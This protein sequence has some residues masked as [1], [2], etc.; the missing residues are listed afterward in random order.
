MV[1]ISISHK[2]SGKITFVRKEPCAMCH[3]ADCFTSTT[4]LILSIASN[5][6]NRMIFHF[7]EERT[8]FHTNK[9][10]SKYPVLHQSLFFLLHREKGNMFQHHSRDP[11]SNSIPLAYRSCRLNRME[12]TG[13]SSEKS[14]VLDDDMNPQDPLTSLIPTTQASSGVLPVQILDFDFFCPS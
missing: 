9:R 12:K 1:P 8:C 13:S 4:H 14:R 10:P 11:R 5:I 3:D 7:R 2:E 6:A